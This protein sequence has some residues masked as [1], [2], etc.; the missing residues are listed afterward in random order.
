MTTL[1]S[2]FSKISDPRIERHKMHNLIDIFVITVCASICGADT[3]NQIETYGKTK[4]DWLKKI[5]ELPNGIPSHDTFRRVFILIDPN[6]FRQCFIN[7]VESLNSLLPTSQVISI[8][9]KTL[10]GSHNKKDNK[11]AIHMV[12]A[13]AS[14]MNMVIGQLKTEEK[15]NEITAIPKLLDMLDISGSIVTIDAMGCQKK[16]AAKIIDNDADYVLSL[17]KNQETL[18]D[19]V[20]LFF[21]DAKNTDFKDIPHTYDETI[22][23]D[24]G[25]IEVRRHWLVPDIDW[26]QG[27]HLWKGLS[28]IGMVERERDIDGKVTCET[29]YYIL[30]LECDAKEFAVFARKHWGIENKLHWGLDVSFREDEC[31]KRTGNSAENF[32]MI[33]HISL[34]LLKQENS[35]KKSIKT[36]RLEAGWND[37]Y[38]MKILG[39]NTI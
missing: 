17:K 27:K 31:R 12:S 39:V 14:E 7:W 1:V 2:E 11:S 34:N 28:S 9:G 25:R 5:L 22:D 6:E 30:S 8:D 26:L 16:I 19:D 15:S 35:M 38:L 23:G 29:S 18:H 24:H 33:R 21:Q 10:R 20:E 3:W 32:A 13:W 4:Y 36:K 37:K